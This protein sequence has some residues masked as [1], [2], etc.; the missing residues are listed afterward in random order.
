MM[1]DAVA[2]IERVT[3]QETALRAFWWTVGAL[4]E[5]VVESGVDPVSA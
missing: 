1:R 3:A 4:L 5:A 2:G